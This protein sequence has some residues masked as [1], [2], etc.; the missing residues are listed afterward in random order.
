[1]D[2]KYIPQQTVSKKRIIKIGLFHLMSYVILGYGL[3]QIDPIF[4]SWYVLS[5]SYIIEGLGIF[6]HW[7]G[8]RRWI[9]WWYR[10]HME[11]HLHIYPPSK[12]LTDEYQPTESK[13]AKAYA[14]TILLSPFIGCYFT[15]L[16]LKTYLVGLGL[17]TGLLKIADELHKA[18]HRK[19]TCLE[20]YNWFQDIRTLHYYHHKGDMKHNYGI[21]NFFWDYILGVAIF[22]W[23]FN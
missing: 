17:S 6:T 15:G 9:P 18:V 7:L 11:H 3:N 1:M 16:N 22:T 13:N 14:F 23:D 8:H 5:M 10:A 21:S 2:N 20:K 19:N 12:F 4:P